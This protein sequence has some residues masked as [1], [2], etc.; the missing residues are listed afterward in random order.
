MLAAAARARAAGAEVV[1]ASLHCCLEYRNDPT[2]AQVAAV[3]TLLASPDIDLVIGQHAHVV[4]AAERIGTEYVVYG[5]GNLLSNQGAPETPVPSNDGVIVTVT[6]TEQ[7]DGTWVQSAT[8]TPT[9]VDRS[10]HVI[11]KAT[12]TSNPQSY[13][14]TVAAL[15]GLG[16]GTFDG[17]PTS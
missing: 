10:T 8:Y 5:T 16:P 9:Y 12:P 17:V 3:R 6:F 13:E 11:R 2:E 7:P 1:V 4:Q 15:N 14:R